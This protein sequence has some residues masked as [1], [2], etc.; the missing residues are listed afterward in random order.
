MAWKSKGSEERR[1]G[2]AKARKSEGLE[3]R[4]LGRAKARKSEGSEERRLGRAKARKSEGVEERRLEE[5][6]LGR[7]KAQKS[8]GSEERRLGGAKAQKSEGSEERRRGRAKERS[9]RWRQQS[10]E[11]GNQQPNLQTH[12]DS[13]IPSKIAAA[14]RPSHPLQHAIRKISALDTVYQN[15]LPFKK[16]KLSLES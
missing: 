13:L 8:E 11:D 1:L 12:S 10:G 3:E 6:R 5:R 9:R 15:A 4:R 2:R 16:K 7:A 14:A